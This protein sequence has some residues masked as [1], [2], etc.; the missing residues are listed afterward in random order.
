LICKKKNFDKQVRL[1]Q[2]GLVKSQLREQKTSTR[3]RE[4]Q[5]K[6]LQRDIREN[7]KN[8]LKRNL[9]CFWRSCLQ[10]YYCYDD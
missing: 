10:K 1:D 5:D 7:L 6:T 9:T 8:T 4:L 2:D 3:D